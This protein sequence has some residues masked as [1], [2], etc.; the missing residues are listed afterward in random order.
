MNKFIS[1][2]VSLS[3]LLGCSAIQ[4]IP[5]AETVEIVNEVPNRE[6]CLF[7]G[8]IIDSQ[9]SWAIGDYTS[10]KNLVLGA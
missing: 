10:N 9:G 2:A 6:R 4:A 3:L 1:V 8:E 7:R 5:G